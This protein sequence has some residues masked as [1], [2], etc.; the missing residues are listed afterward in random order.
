[1]DLEKI[2]FLTQK[3]FIKSKVLNFEFVDSGLLNKTYIVEH[4]YNGIKSKFILQSLSNIFASHEI[5]NINHKLITDHIK[6]KIN[7][8]FSCFDYRKW[9][10]PSLIRCKSNNLFSFYFE[11][12]YWRAMIYID[13]VFSLDCLEDQIMAYQTGIGLAKFHLLC[14]DFDCTK[15]DSSIKN[16][17]NTSY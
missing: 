1:M 8:N 2:N 14:S 10:V 5:V 7:K 17:H 15:L 11:S 3:F 6:G 9:I 16:F 4:L 12:V 13:E